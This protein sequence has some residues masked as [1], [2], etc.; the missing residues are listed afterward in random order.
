MSSNQDQIVNHGRMLPFCGIRKSSRKHLQLENNVFYNTGTLNK[1]RFINGT[2]NFYIEALTRDQLR[3][4]VIM[5]YLGEQ[6]IIEQKKRN[7]SANYE[8][9][10][11]QLCAYLEHFSLKTGYTL[12]FNFNKEKEQGIPI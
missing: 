10:E 3:T 7:G 11:Q 9:G 8:K 4:D 1:S 6:F 12:T 5:D 2:G